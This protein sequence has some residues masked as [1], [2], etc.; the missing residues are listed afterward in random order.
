MNR[1][2][3]NGIRWWLGVISYGTLFLFIGVFAYMKMSFL[4]NGVQIEAVIERTDKSPL[5]Y[6]KGVA[7]N[8]TYIT[9][10][11]REIFIDREGRFN[12]PIALISGFSVVT[13]DAKDKFGKK[14]E[15]K[16]QLVYEEPNPQVAVVEEQKNY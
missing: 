9:I 6:V 7:K 10:N 8:A 2:K 11:G 4:L 5:A 14:D 16:F 15:M 12:E 3:D 13:I 1:L